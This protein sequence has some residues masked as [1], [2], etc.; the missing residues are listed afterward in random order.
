M[1]FQSPAR[2]KIFCLRL[3]IMRTT[4]THQWSQMVFACRG[5]SG[6]SLSA[7]ASAKEDRSRHLFFASSVHIRTH[8]Y[9]SVKTRDSLAAAKLCEAGSFLSLSSAALAKADH[10]SSFIFYLLSFIF[11]NSSHIFPFFFK[12]SSLQLFPLGVFYW[13]CILKS[14]LHTVRRIHP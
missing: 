7:A 10:L 8:P 5:P 14:C 11:H 13:N 4:N 3:G 2:R 1:F 6:G 12:N 9:R